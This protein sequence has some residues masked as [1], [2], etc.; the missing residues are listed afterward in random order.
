M[1]A[2]LLSGL[3]AQSTLVAALGLGGLWLLRRRSPLDR[4]AWLKL[5]LVLLLAMPLLPRFS[6]TVPHALE[7][8]MPAPAPT[9]ADIAPTITQP[10]Q[11]LP[12]SVPPVIR[13]TIRLSTLLML[14]YGLGVAALLGRL[15]LGVALLSSWTRRAAPLQD[16]PWRQALALS[17]APASTRLVVSEKVGAPLSWGLRHPTIMI[18]PASARRPGDASAIL[19]HEAAHI[20]HGD[21]LALMAARVAVALFWFN[22]L[23][24]VLTRALV[25]HCEEAA[26]AQ[27]L[28]RCAPTDYAETLMTCLSGC[29]GA[30]RLA[31]HARLLPA[32]GMAAG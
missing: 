14:A 20:A 5:A 27:A 26:D 13:P 31:D 6:L 2:A 18:D 29:L 25:Q 3:A 4:A 30:G 23:V 9:V 19:A 15:L 1:T 7:G 32:N 21:W 11:P 16:H 17:G 22:P 10:D 12:Q 28:T 24:W 8:L